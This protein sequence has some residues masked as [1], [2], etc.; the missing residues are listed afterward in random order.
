MLLGS[1]GY[2]YGFAV[3]DMTYDT[4]LALSEEVGLVVSYFHL[5]RRGYV[6]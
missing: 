2:G 5:G 4:I 1:C 6:G 3:V